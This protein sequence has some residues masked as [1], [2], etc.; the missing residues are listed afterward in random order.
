MAK[1][2]GITKAL[3]SERNE[4]FADKLSNMVGFEENVAMNSVSPT[5]SAMAAVV[6][7]WIRIAADRYN[8][9]NEYK[10]SAIAV[11]EKDDGSGDLYFT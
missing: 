5:S 9:V 2:G 1:F 7:Q 3:P 10:Y 11:A 8:M 6:E 4:Y